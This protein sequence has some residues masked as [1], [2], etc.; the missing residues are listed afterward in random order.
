[1][2]ASFIRTDM[3]P[4]LKWA[5]R[6]LNVELTV[7]HRLVALSLKFC[8]TAGRTALS[9]SSGASVISHRPMILS[10][11]VQGIM[12]RLAL[13]FSTSKR[14]PLSASVSPVSMLHKHVEVGV[15]DNDCY[16]TL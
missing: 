8:L 10:R 7:L 12:K 1:M 9:S 16:L 2:N 6:L 4:S 5:V 11:P 13:F 14:I 3:H 15:S